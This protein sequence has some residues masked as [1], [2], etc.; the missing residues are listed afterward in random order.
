MTVYNLR[1]SNNA[2]FR[3]TRDLTQFA[4]TYSLASATIRMAARL[5]P[6]APDPPAYEWCSTNTTGGQITV[7]SATNLAVFSAPESD[8]AA[9]GGDL[10]YDCRLEFAGGVAQVIFGGRLT[11]AEGITRCAAGLAGSGVSGVGDTVTVDG[12]RAASQVPLPLSLTA[13][14]AA[15]QG[16][17]LT[18]AALL[19]A[20]AAFTPAQ[21]TAL[22]A[23]IGAAAGGG[24][25]TSSGLSLDLSAPG[26]FWW[27]AGGGSSG[28]GSNA[29]SPPSD[30]GALAAIGLALDMSIP[31]NF[32]LN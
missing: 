16:A 9:L 22:Q 24:T 5:Y 27:G 28:S 11:V 2:T 1:A 32:W 6:E 17:A 3:W 7:N 26:N 14:I 21:I 20:I 19:A 18:P 30:G 31:G 8:M 15:A 12:E 25:S 13:A 4:T 10:V 29:A 23:I